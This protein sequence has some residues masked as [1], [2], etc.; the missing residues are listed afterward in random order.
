MGVGYV[1]VNTTKREYIS[2]S[3]LGSNTKRELT[4][5]AVTA[6]I[7]SWYLLEHPGDNI[8]FASDSE[9]GW[10]GWPFKSGSWDDLRKY[11]EVT[12]EVVEALIKA[13]ILQDEGKDIFDATEP[14]VYVRLLRNIWDTRS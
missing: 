2:F 4:G 1:L 10:R 11:R 12:D 7:T 6:A 13:E 5:D 8:A 9:D 14:E 3:H